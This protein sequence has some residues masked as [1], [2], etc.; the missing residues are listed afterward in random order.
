M[1]SS[2]ALENFNAE[3][4]SIYDD[5]E[6]FDFYRTVNQIFN[7]DCEECFDIYYTVNQIF[8]EYWKTCSYPEWSGHVFKTEDIA[9]SNDVSLE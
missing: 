5:K 6:C 9:Q 4:E 8:K 1:A 3:I 2:T 7:D